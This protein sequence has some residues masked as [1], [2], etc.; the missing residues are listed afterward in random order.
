MKFEMLSIHAGQEPD[1]LAGAVMTSIYQ[2]ST[3][4]WRI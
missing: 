4:C 3:Y 1:P 2:T